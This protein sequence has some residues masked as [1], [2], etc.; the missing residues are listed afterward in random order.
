MR[1]FDG[2]DCGMGPGQGWRAWLPP[3]GSNGLPRTFRDSA[4][5]VTAGGYGPPADVFIG[6]DVMLYVIEP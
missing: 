5:A 2:V 4:N 3:T 6:K 1:T